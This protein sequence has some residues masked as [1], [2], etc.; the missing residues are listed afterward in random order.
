MADVHGPLRVT[1]SVTI[2]ASELSWQFSRSSG[3][4]GQSVNT[5]DSRV[6]LVWDLAHSTAISDGQR[7]RATQRLSRR[8]HDGLLVVVAAEHR[9]QWQ[10][11]HAARERLAT[12]IRTAIAAPGARRRTGRPS[13]SSIERRLRAKNRRA[14]VKQHRRP[15]GPDD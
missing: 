14:D 15:P 9:S 12:L 5:T 6:E 3:P 8:V 13:R 2:P 11:R 7:A 1:R 10:N 4:G